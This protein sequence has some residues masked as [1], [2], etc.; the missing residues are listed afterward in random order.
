MCPCK[1]YRID[2]KCICGL[3]TKVPQTVVTN[4]EEVVGDDPNTENGEKE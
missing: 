2:G 4:E 1:N 3:F